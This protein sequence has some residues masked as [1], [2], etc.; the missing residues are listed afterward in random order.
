[1]ETSAKKPVP[2]MLM[3]VGA[4]LGFLLFAILMLVTGWGAEWQKDLY[5]EK[6]ARLRTETTR[7]L[8]EADVLQL[9]NL[10]W[11][12]R[13]AGVVRIPV[14]QAIDLTMAELADQPITASEVSVIPPLP[15]ETPAEGEPATD[16]TAEAPT[17]SET[18]ASD[19][20]AEGSEATPSPEDS[21]A[22]PSEEAAPPTPEPTEGA[23]S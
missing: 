5:E 16:A 18:T 17:A 4:L 10:E 22:A 12:D 23:G 14:V 15:P 13:E 11:I 2:F 20:P 6:R 1:M 21:T 9:T 3:L 8:T 19:A 7:A